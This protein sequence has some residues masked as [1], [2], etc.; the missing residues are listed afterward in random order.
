MQGLTAI[1]GRACTAVKCVCERCGESVVED[2][3]VD[4]KYTPDQK[5]VEA[6]GINV[7]YDFVEVDEF[8]EIDLVTLV[9]DEL[10]LSLP[11]V[12]K[13]DVCPN[14]KGEWVSGEIEEDTKANPF[15]VLNELKSKKN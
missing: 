8:G 5:K 9:E 4:F 6:L 7:E 13:H 10:I 14:F 11:I 3:A 1:E 2:L 15:A 12:P